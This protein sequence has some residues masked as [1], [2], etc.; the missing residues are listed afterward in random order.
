MYGWV[1]FLS[2]EF[3]RTISSTII[4]IL[5]IKTQNTVLTKEKEKTAI[6]LI[7]IIKTK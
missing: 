7:T 5:K 1:T 4:K 6:V 3:D 2:A